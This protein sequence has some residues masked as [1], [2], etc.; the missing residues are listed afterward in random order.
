[1]VQSERMQMQ[2]LQEVQGHYARWSQVRR[3]ATQAYKSQGAAS[4]GRGLTAME[5]GRD[6]W[7]LLASQ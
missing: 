5:E 7:I 2:K 4:V 3:R 6:Q 1:M